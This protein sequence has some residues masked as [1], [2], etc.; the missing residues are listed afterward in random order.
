[1]NIGDLVKIKSIDGL[2]GI[3]TKIYPHI[4][5]LSVAAK[6]PLYTVTYSDGSSDDWWSDE[7]EIIKTS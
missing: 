5:P 2:F 7:L 6:S 4:H 1:M 3:I